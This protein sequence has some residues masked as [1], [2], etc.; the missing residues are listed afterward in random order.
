MWLGLVARD[1]GDPMAARSL[2]EESVA[3][4]REIGDQWALA[5]SLVSL[6][7]TVTMAG[8]PAAARSILEEGGTIFREIGDKYGYA[9]SLNNLGLVALRQ[10]DYGRAIA[11]YKEGVALFW[12]VGEKVFATRCLEELAWVACVQGDYERATR[13][14]GAAEAQRETFGGF[15]LP[16]ARTEHDRS[17]AAACAQLGEAAFA[18]AWAEGR[19]MSMEQAIAYALGRSD[20]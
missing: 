4:F 9:L 18:A 13:L 10:G 20:V 7:R 5:L 11:L 16:A 3:I 19:A 14:F 17:V 1:P 12:Q 6:G 8:D 15:I 2:L